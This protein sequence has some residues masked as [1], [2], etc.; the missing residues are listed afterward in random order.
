M[1]DPQDIIVQPII[2]E[3]SME[4]MESN[5]TYSFKVANDSNKIEIRNAIE[6]IFNVKVENV[7][8]MNMRGKKRRMGRNEGKRPDWKK[9][10]VKLAEGDN[11]EVFEGL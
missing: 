3:Q 8:T 5:N 9:A 10:Y 7:N 2:S 1:K 4:L 11:I 6:E